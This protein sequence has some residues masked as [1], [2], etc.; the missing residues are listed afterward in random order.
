MKKSIILTIA[1]LLI[2]VISKSQINLETQ[3]PI[4][5]GNLQLC[6]L[7][8]GSYKYYYYDKIKPTK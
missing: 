1:T 6:N 3:Y 7:T 5:M 4:D 8:T 2:A